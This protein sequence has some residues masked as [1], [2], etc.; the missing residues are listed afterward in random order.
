MEWRRSGLGPGRLTVTLCLTITLCLAA[1][2]VTA[3]LLLAARP[4][5]D[6]PAIE[7][8]RAAGR[9]RLG[10]RADAKPFSYRDPTGK[11][12]GYSV[13]LC[14]A[15]ASE[16]KRLPGLA[17][18]PVEWVAVTPDDRFEAVQ[19]A[20]I[21]VLCGASTATLARRTQ[22]SFSLPIFAGGIG[23]IRRVDAPLGLR[24]LLADRLQTSQPAWR[25]SARQVLKGRTFAAVQG[26]SGESW[27]VQWIKE[28]DGS[29]K[30]ER[31]GGY[32]AGIQALVDRKVDVFFGERAVALDTVKRHPYSKDLVAVDRL[33]TFEPL[34]L[35]I[36]RNDDDL[37]LLVDAVLSRMYRSGEIRGIY[38]QSF[39]QPDEQMLTF[40][41]W[42]TLPE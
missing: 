20:H 38:A 25:A 8:I 18:I 15:I 28:L 17:A 33:F 23:A 41:R 3:P 37:R 27:L 10:Y 39:G 5:A 31:V 16:V 1:A 19:Q 24:E 6:S 14:Q 29:A 36:G 2:L 22:V 35:A 32:D 9:I 26:T 11:P 21:D 13:A 42:H 30:I 7:R 4:P 40:L 12:A 34:A